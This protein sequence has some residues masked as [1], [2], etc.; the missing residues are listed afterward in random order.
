MR[1]LSS[2]LA[3]LALVVGAVGCASPASSPSASDS[4]SASPVATP[5][6][7]PDQ[8]EHPTGAT[9]VVFR[10]SEGGGLMF[11]EIRANEA[12]I[13]TLYGDGRIIV[14]PPSDIPP[15][16]GAPGPV[17]PQAPWRTARLDEAQ[18][19]ELLRFAIVEGSLGIARPR[20]E[21]PTVM[22]AP[23]AR[24]EVNAGGVTKA[25]EVYALREEADPADRAHRV[26]FA[27]LADRLRSLGNDATEEYKPD[28]YRGTLWESGPVA[29]PTVEPWPWPDLAPADFVAPADPSGLA[30]PRRAMTQA[31]IDRLAIGDV[32]GGVTGLYFAG[33]GGNGIYAFALRPLLPDEKE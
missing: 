15:P 32:G 25:V 7:T 24:F 2:Y 10:F 18:M 13:F 5:T 30:L 9:D 27:A 3:A 12:P 17:R 6:A 4:G 14:Q 29:G 16:I 22:D 31:E 11:P 33:P 19:R 20:Y 26:A 1:R 8:L 23:T 21:L 28:R